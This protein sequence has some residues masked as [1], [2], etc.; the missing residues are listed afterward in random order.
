MLP[1]DPGEISAVGQLAGDQRT[2]SAQFYTWEQWAA[3]FFLARFQFYHMASWTCLGHLTQAK[4]GPAPAASASPRNLLAIQNLRPYPD[5]S[6]QKSGRGASNLCFNKLSRQLRC[7]GKSENHWSTGGSGKSE[8]L[9]PQAASYMDSGTESF[10]I[11]SDS[12][13]KDR[14][15]AQWAISR[16]NVT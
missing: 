9:A 16:K 1:K 5:S 12:R 14:K 6:N 15:R 8:T 4:C 11:V 7:T 2:Y 13:L 3:L 10:Q